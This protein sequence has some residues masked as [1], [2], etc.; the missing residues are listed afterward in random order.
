[1]AGN[2]A[3]TK[4]RKRGLSSLFRNNKFLLIISLVI[5]VVVWITMSLSDTH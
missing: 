5:A 3:R 2:R 4:R 1:M